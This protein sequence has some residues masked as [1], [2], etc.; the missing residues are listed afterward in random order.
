MTRIIQITDIH[1]T[2]PP[3][4]VSG[5]LNTHALFEK[6]I[7]KIE[8][9]LPLFGDIDAIIATGDI[10]DHG[11]VESYELFKTQISRLNIPYL[12]IP[13]NHDSR[14]AMLTSFPELSA[15]STNGE[16]NWV[17]SFSAFDVIGLDTVIPHQGAGALS[18][19]TLQFLAQAL[20]EN[21]DKPAL[22]AMHHPPFE[23]GIC[24]MDNIG[25]NGADEMETLLKLTTREVRVI[26]GHL[27]NSIVCSMGNATVL[28]S[29]AV[30]SSFMT[31]HRPNA[32][33]GFTQKPGGYMLHEWNNGFRSS[34][35]SLS[36]NGDL[37]PF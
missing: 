2:V 16:I 14:E 27:H 24:F 22:I 19:S 6:A 29:P 28:S 35:L 12:V 20:A 3:H 33:V 1:L 23:S 21:P 26:C 34:Y 8:Q 15:S 9:D 36:P 4:K 37:Y 17:R 11:D 10:T 18:P 25:L 13:G 5:Q 31:D 7:D 30:A 32:P